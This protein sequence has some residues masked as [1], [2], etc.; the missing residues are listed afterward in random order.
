MFW[1]LFATLG[2]AVGDPLGATDAATEAAVLGL[3]LGLGLG[4]AAAEQAPTMIESSP[5]AAAQ[6]DNLEWVGRLRIFALLLVRL[7]DSDP[8]CDAGRSIHGYAAL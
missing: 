8:T 7:I 2:A 5:T 6:A 1:I 4:L 3:G